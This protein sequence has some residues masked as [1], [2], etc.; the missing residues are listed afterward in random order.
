VAAV[1]GRLRER[2]PE[3]SV[4]NRLADLEWNLPSGEIA[5]CGGVAMVRAE[6][7]R[8][9]GGF[10][11]T[12]I[13]AED[14]E[15]CLRLRA[16]GGTIVRLDAE[17]ATHDMAMTRF[18]QWWRRSVRT[19]HAYA[20]GTALHGRTPERHFVRQTRSAVFWGLAVPALALGLAWPT[21][22]LSLALLG[23][24]LV[25][26]RKTRRYYEVQR[27]WPRGDAGLYAA[28][29]VLAKFP[30]ALGLLRYWAGR[31]SGRRSGVIEHRV[32]SEQ[33]QAI[34]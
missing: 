15:L 23:G 34:G 20:E 7:F 9:V 17:M 14:D 27:G 16:R 31:L 12:I 21:R 3:R 11:P 28:W 8:A 1:C 30:Q 6:A 19:G 26:H 32:G 33:T 10:D 29:I 18:A 2:F 25:L 22:F 13:A 5:A 24:Y 4:Y